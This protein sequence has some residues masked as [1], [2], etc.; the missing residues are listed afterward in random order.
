MKLSALRY[1]WAQIWIKELTQDLDHR[2]ERQTDLEAQL[3]GLQMRLLDA[4]SLVPDLSTDSRLVPADAAAA[5]AAAAATA[6]ATATA[7]AAEGTRAAASADSHR[8]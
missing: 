7:T 2:A 8:P 6:T 3:Q 5:A 1:L 4:Q